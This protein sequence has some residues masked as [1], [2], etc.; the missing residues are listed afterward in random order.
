MLCNEAIKY[1][2]S[3][4][5]RAKNALTNAMRVL[6][7]LG[8]CIKCGEVKVFVCD[9]PDEQEALDAMIRLVESG[10]GE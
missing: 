6:S 1:K 8:G 5:F 4:K 9:G 7:V 3:V 10:L 2:A